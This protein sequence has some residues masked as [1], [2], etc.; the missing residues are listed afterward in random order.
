MQW[1]TKLNE[2]SLVSFRIKIDK[3]KGRGIVHR[4]GVT[5]DYYYIYII[6]LFIDNGIGPYWDWNIGYRQKLIVII[7]VQILVI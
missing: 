7:S 1:E 4:F 2:Q 6:F 3:F 5:L